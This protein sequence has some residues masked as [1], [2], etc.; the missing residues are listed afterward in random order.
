MLENAGGLCQKSRINSEDALGTPIR[1]ARYLGV[2][3]SR[4]SVLNNINNNIK[5]GGY[6]PPVV[7]VVTIIKI[8]KIRIFWKF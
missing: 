5:K 4:A 2:R 7:V 3:R 1:R 8:G 6:N